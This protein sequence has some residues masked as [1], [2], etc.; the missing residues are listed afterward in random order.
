MKR[1]F[2]F[3]LFTRIFIFLSILFMIYLPINDLFSNGIKFDNIIIIII[4][5]IFLGVAVY[6]QWTL[7]IFLNVK[8]N[9]I[10]ISF[11]MDKSKN[12]ER[13]LSDIE[14]IS[15][16][17]RKNYGFVFIIKHK[18]GYIE[19]INYKFF[20]LVWLESIQSK[21]IKRKLKELNQTLK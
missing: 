13:A 15:L 20:R 3:G 2:I 11:Y 10:T 6:W 21:R 12:V 4:L 16:E 7:G 18:N 5:I 19:K 14:S 9:R 8:K 1:I 17:E